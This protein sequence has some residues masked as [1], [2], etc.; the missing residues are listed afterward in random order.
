MWLQLLGLHDV[1]P[2]G[3][4]SRAGLQLSC[5]NALMHAYSDNR[6]RKGNPMFLSLLS[7]HPD[8]WPH[9]WGLAGPHF[10]YISEALGM[11]PGSLTSKKSGVGNTEAEPGPFRGA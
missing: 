5:V 8:L 6:D 2:I 11:E 9:R 4:F 3:R 10:P 1:G 7:L